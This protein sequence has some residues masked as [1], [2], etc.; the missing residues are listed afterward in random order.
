MLFPLSGTVF[1][2]ILISSTSLVVL[3]YHPWSGSSNLVYLFSE[4]CL[5]GKPSPTVVFYP[6][7]PLLA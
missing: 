5:I 1:P 4:N 6:L 7:P 3:P 2:V